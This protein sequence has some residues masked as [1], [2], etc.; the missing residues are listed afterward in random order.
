VQS[1]IM[2]RFECVEVKAKELSE[3]TKKEEEIKVQAKISSN[4]DK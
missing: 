2:F 1:S 3:A 4:R